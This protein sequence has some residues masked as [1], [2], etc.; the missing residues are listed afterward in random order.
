V[1]VVEKNNMAQKPIGYYGEFRPTGVDQSAARRFEALAGLADQVGD[2]AFQIGAKRAEKIGAEKGEKAGRAAAE[3]LAKPQPEVGPPEDVEPPK[4]KEGFLA[5]MSI[6]AQAYNAAMKSAYFSQVSTDAKEQVERIAAQYPDDVQ[7]F[8]SNIQQYSQGLLQGVSDEFK[9][10]AEA[11]IANYIANAETAVFKNQVA[12]NRA[13]ANSSRQ[14]AINLHNDESAKMAR[15]GDPDQAIVN[16]QHHD[17][18]IDSMVVSGD[19]AA[20]DAQI[21]KD[22]LAKRIQQQT[23]L[24]ELERVIF[25]ENLSTRE[26]YEKGVAFVER[27]RDAELE[28]I[29][30]EDKDKL[31]SVLDSKIESLRVGL[32]REES[33]ISVEQGRVISDLMIAASTG[34]RPSEEI[35]EEANQLYDSGVIDFRKR[36]S[37]ITTASKKSQADINKAEAISKVAM[38][39]SGDTTAM[40]L[41]KDVNTFYDEYESNYLGNPANQA[42]FV[43]RTGVVPSKMKQRLET[44]INSGD[45]VRMEQAIE[46]IDRV[47]ELPGMFGQL[48]TAGQEAFATQVVTLSEVMPMDQA[49]KEARRIV[50]PTNATYIESRRKVIKDQK[51]PEKYSKWTDDVFPYF[52]E[53]PVGVALSQA[54]R[55]F[56]I[57]FENYFTNGLDA[58]QAQQKAKKIMQTNWTDSEFGVMPYAPE[59]YYP[60]SGEVLRDQAYQQAS[61]QIGKQVKKDNIYLLTNDHTARTASRGRPEYIVMYREEDGTL[62]TIYDEVTGQNL[63]WYPDVDQAIERQKEEVKKSMEER[64][65]AGITGEEAALAATY[66]QPI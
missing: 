64:R 28:D 16:Q 55:Q 37:I 62:S 57:L 39:I 63:Y 18:V 26:Q 6:E 10:S 9:E 22:S 8:Q 48:V 30:P 33:E 4:T 38:K 54:E 20:D 19:L 44:D 61:E 52:T 25:D 66:L 31:L 14:L 45:P 47:D 11:T 58:S 50:D 59:Q 36:A 15:D 49:V 53:K 42:L 2:I 56:G 34:S 12:K 5:S 51:Y 1:A 24:G 27:I 23:Q 40:P 65:A 29:G 46:L 13:I 60:I 21:A 43:Q 35:V 7:A 32:S 41:E 3:R 17:L